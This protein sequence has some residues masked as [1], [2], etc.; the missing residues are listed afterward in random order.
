M[1]QA[2]FVACAGLAFAVFMFSID[3]SGMELM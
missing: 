3:I 2:N 1:S